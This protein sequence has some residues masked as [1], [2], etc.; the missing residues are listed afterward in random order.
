M[1]NRVFTLLKFTL[2][3]LLVV[4]AIIALLASILLPSLQKAKDKAREIQCKNN[5]KQYGIYCLMY[6]GD[7]S[8]WLKVYGDNRW[9]KSIPEIPANG[10]FLERARRISCP[11]GV[12]TLNEY[13]TYGLVLDTDTSLGYSLVTASHVWYNRIGNRQ[14]PSNYDFMADTAYMIGDQID[15]YYKNKSGSWGMTCIR[16]N[17]QANLFFADGHVSNCTRKRLREIDTNY[18]RTSNGTELTTF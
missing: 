8:G 2:L 13:H 4:I 9:W 7:N 3:E 6:A 18:V 11:S 10:T 17:S 16:H 5:L 15:Y 14:N 12:S 1:K